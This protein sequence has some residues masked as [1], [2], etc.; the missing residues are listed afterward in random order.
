MVTPSNPSLSVASGNTSDVSDGHPSDSNSASGPRR[1]RLID[2]LFVPVDI[3]PLVFFRIFFGAMMLYHVLSWVK[4]WW[5][6]FFL[7]RPDFHLT[8]PG[9]EWVQPWP[10]NWMYVHFALMGLASV[11]IMVGLLYRLSATVF[12]L[13]VTHVFLIEKA[14]YQNHYYL[15]CLIS[16]LMIFVPAHHAGSIDALL[17]PGIRSPVAPSIWLWLL[18][19]QLG[20]PY[21]YGGLAKLNYDWLHGMPMKLWLERRT[22]LPIVGEWLGHDSAAIL[23]S[24]GGLIFDL[25]VVPALFWRRTRMI[26][27]LLCVCFHL[28]NSVLWEIGIFPWFMI[29]ATLLFFPPGWVRKFLSMRAV[30]PSPMPIPPSTWSP[31]QRVV[32]TIIGLY[33]TWQLLFPFRHYLYPGV[34][35]WTEE[36]HHFAWHMMLREKDLGI[37][38]FVYNRDTN[39]RGLLQVSDFLNERQLTRMGKDPDMIIEF[40]HYVR[41]HY[42]EHDRG[43][44]EI[45][46]LALTSLNG[47]K[48]QLL[49]DP[50]LDYASVDRVWGTQPWIIPLTEP[51]RKEGW[52]LPL[53]QWTTELGSL[54]PDDM[55]LEQTE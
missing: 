9:F 11:G 34:V 25:L 7:I 44:L 30:L 38:F 29:G 50:Y 4:K 19:F 27:Y 42:R 3:A 15:I 41:D 24:Y 43:D 12:F 1:A 46:V 55:K 32:A 47:R 14:L 35:S 10:G 13:G 36:G 49:I 18:R 21:F 5:I 48:P 51:L 53:D 8:Y 17:R 54:I 22:S 20:I 39:Q 33:L 6:D 16:G 45:R 26:A 31:R 2:Q 40:V 52:K 28:A 37:R 23:F